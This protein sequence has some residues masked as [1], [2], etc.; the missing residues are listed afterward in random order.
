MILPDEKIVLAVSGGPDSIALLYLMNELRDE[1]KCSFH[2]A[3]LDHKLRGSE[4]DEDVRFVADQASKLDMP[5]TIESLDVKNMIT[6]KESLESGARRIRYDFYERVMFQ[7]H[8]N[9]VAQGHTA[10]DQVETVIM[11]FLRGSGSQGLSAIPPIRG[12]KYIR[13]LIE[14]SRNEIEE[15]L[16]EINVTPRRDSS[17]LST[18][19]ERNRIRH[20]LLP[21]LEEKYSPNIKNILQQ[22]ADILRED[23]SFLTELSQ[24]VADDCVEQKDT[25]HIIIHIPIF[26]DQHLA[27]QRRILRLAIESLLGNLLRYDFRHIRD[28]I[29]LVNGDSS[30]KSIGLPRGIVAEKSYDSLILRLG[31][32]IRGQTADYS[33]LIKV[34]GRTDIPELGLSIITKLEQTNSLEYSKNRFEKT[35]D[36]DGISGDLKIRNRKNGDRFQPLGM[37][38]SKKIKDIFI[39]QKIPKLERN[40]IPILVDGNNILWLIGYQIDERVKVTTKTKTKLSVT[41]SFGGSPIS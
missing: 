3:H 18:E 28:L 37:S 39:N 14:I 17:N 8:A 35:F 11:R 4:S 41:V 7:T 24:K 19:Y 2:I 34:P 36:Y 15:Y 33:Y 9:K 38:G 27:M 29:D 12:N 6:P 16:Q 5:I 30:G 31:D 25:R 1:L 26:R 10:D 22:T 23:D 32:D 13:P 40:N 20:E 21:L